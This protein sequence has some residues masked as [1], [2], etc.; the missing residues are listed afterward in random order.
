MK[1]STSIRPFRPAPG[2]KPEEQL[3]VHLGEAVKLEPPEQGVG[4]VDRAVVGAED[5]AGPD[6]AVVLIDLLVAARAPAGV[7]QEQRGAVVDPGQD[8][9]ERLVGERTD[10]P[11]PAA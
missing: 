7:A 3:A 5:V 8:L 11:A 10:R 4:V 9:V 6:R 2:G 1:R